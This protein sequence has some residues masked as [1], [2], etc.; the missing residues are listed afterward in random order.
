[1][2][3]TNL[4]TFLDVARTALQ[5]SER[6]YAGHRQPKPNGEPGEVL[7][8][9]PESKSLKNALVAIAFSG[10]YFEALMYIEGCRCVGKGDY[11]AVERKWGSYTKKLKNVFSVTDKSVLASCERFRRSRNDLLHEKAAD[12][13]SLIGLSHSKDDGIEFRV[14]QT[15]AR[16]AFDFITLVTPL[17]RSAPNKSLNR[18]RFSGRWAC[19]NFMWL[20]RR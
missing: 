4:L 13:S 18:T 7:T 8:L 15:E 3:M 19:F 17:L 20:S 11:D 5:E 1:M 10:I 6:I 14:A 12:L 2:P 16:H 9:D